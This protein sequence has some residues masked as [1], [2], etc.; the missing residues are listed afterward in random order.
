MSVAS[1][2]RGTLSDARESDKRRNARASPGMTA[3][4]IR[5]SWI[6]SRSSDQLLERSTPR[7]ISDDPVDR[8]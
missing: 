6:D 3:I 2:F 5:S 1:A 4:E 8:L 7:T